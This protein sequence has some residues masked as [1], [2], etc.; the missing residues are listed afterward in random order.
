MISNLGRFLFKLDIRLGIF[1]KILTSRIHTAS[2]FNTLSYNL[3]I[4]HAIHDLY[5]N[6]DAV[7]VNVEFYIEDRV[8]LCVR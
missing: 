2:N 4:R 5:T 8:R 7:L 1:R 6:I 3:Q